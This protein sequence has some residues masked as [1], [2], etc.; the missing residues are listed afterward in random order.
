MKK[1]F[2]I[3]SII[4]MSVTS[5]FAAFYVDLYG[6]FVGLDD[7]ENQLGFGGG[8]GFSITDYLNVAARIVHTEKTVDA[9]TTDEMNYSNESFLIGLE[10]IPK[11]PAIERYQLSWHVTLLGGMSDSSVD[12]NGI[13]GGGD[14]MGVAISFWTGP[15]FDLTQYVSFFA[16]FGYNYNVH[17]GEFEDASVQ[18][19]QAMVGIRCTLFGSRDYSEGY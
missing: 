11:I 19:F 7:L 9:N 5:S 15:H 2:L 18:G 14:D 8:F 3:L 4:F 6:A 12:G 16:E 1:L 10:Y 13:T 17:S